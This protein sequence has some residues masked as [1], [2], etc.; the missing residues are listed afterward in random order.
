[1]KVVK[2]DNRHKF[3]RHGFSSALRFNSCFDGNIPR[4]ERF[5]REKYGALPWILRE[6]VQHPWIS[7]TS[8]SGSW[9]RQN[10]VYWI[11]VK[12]PSVITMALLS[13]EL[14]NT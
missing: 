1:M 2:L 3:T 4:I 8:S 13:V 6:Q 7:F 10:K 12:N 14:T 9:K 5:L 11:C